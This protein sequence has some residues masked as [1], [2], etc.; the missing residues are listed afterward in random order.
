MQQSNKEKEM[1]DRMERIKSSLRQ[2][3]ALMQQ[4]KEA[5]GDSASKK[6]KLK[7]VK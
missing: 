4:L 5:N 6:P 3:N 2:I 1:H 7:L